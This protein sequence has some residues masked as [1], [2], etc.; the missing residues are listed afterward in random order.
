[1]PNWCENTITITGTPE[2]LNNFRKTMNTI[3]TDGNKVEFTFSQTVPQPNNLVGN[4]WFEW[5]INNWGTKWD[6]NGDANITIMNDCIIIQVQTAWSPPHAW[7]EN[8]TAKFAG[9]KIKLAFF[10]IGVG[11][12][13]VSTYQ[14]GAELKSESEHHDINFDTEYRYD[15]ENEDMILAKHI[16][17]FRN[18]HDIVGY[19]G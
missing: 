16:V 9:L 1:M 10:E 6:V 7:A 17:Q 8:C 15:E 5:N 4:G 14:D 11:Y 13:G 2:S 12:Y 3:D 19:G 18:K